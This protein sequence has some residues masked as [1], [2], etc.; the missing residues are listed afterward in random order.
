[1][2]EI[3]RFLESQHGR[4]RFRRVNSSQFERLSVVTTATSRHRSPRL[5]SRTQRDNASSAPNESPNNSELPDSSPGSG[6]SSGA[7]S[8]TG[9]AGGRLRARVSQQARQQRANGGLSGLDSTAS[10]SSSSIRS[11]DLDG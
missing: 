10:V 8:S 9:R 11:E 7:G 6:R 2:G 1:M 3:V 4:R 5:A